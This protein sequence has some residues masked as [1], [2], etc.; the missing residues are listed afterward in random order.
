M[1]PE[2]NRAGMARSSYDRVGLRI[3]EEYVPA[4]SLTTLRH[5]GRSIGA[6]ARPLWR[7]QGGR[8]ETPFRWWRD[9][10]RSHFRVGAGGKKNL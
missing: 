9:L 3:V 10:S 2:A 7:A 6:V 8:E 1:G 5:K 4:E